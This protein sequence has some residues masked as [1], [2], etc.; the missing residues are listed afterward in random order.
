MTNPLRPVTRLI[1]L[2]WWKWARRELTRRDP[3]HPDLLG[4]VLRINELEKP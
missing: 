3:M 2:A 4:I 1:S